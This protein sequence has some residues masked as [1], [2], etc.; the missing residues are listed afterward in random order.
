MNKTSGISIRLTQRD[1]VTV[2]KAI[3]KLACERKSRVTQSMFALEAINTGFDKELSGYVED[4]ETGQDRI[5]TQI[6][7]EEKQR[8]VDAA[9]KYGLRPTKWA[10]LAIKAYCDD[11]LELKVTGHGLT[12]LDAYYD[13]Q[14]LQHNGLTY[15]RGQHG[16]ARATYNHLDGGHIGLCEAGTGTG[17]AYAC[18]T[19]AHA[20]AVDKK[21]PVV[22]ATYTRALQKQLFET[23]GLMESV[24][25]KKINAAVVYGKRNYVSPTRIK[26]MIEDEKTPKQDAQ[27]LQAWAKETKTW[28]VAD[29]S[30]LLSQD[31]PIDLLAVDPDTKDE[32]ELSAY[33][34]SLADAETADI[35][36][37][38]HHML[39]Y[40]MM[41]KKNP[42]FGFFPD[43]I[44]IDEAH[45]F[46]QAA[47]T[48]L[49]KQVA[50]SSI[51]W[52][53][54]RL[55][56]IKGRHQKPMI[57]WK[58]SLKA[59]A[60]SIVTHCQGNDVIELASRNGL[61][62][63]VIASK[64][65][66]EKL[67]APPK[68]SKAVLNDMSSVERAAYRTIT[69]S[70]SLFKE[71]H[72]SLEAKEPQY[73]NIHAT[74]SPVLK[75]VRI[76]SSSST[77]IAKD[78]QRIVWDK[79]RGASLLSATMLLPT[80]T[81]E[82]AQFFINSVGLKDKDVV[83]EPPTHEAW[84]YD[85]VTIYAAGAEFPTPVSSEREVDGDREFWLS[86]VAEV[87]QSIDRKPVTA[88][89]GGIMVLCTSYADAAAIE[90][91]LVATQ[92]KLIVYHKHDDMRNVVSRF[93]ALDGN[94]ILIGLG[95]LWTGVDLPGNLLTDL[96]ITRL[97]IVSA[98]EKSVISRYEYIKNNAGQGQAFASVLLPRMAMVLRQGI[99][100]VCRSESDFGRVYI[101]DP[102]VVTK[103]RW[104]IANILR[105]YEPI[106]HLET[107]GS[108]HE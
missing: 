52:G 102:R 95:G 85:N 77:F 60:K 36:I 34:K 100:R 35:I 2:E 69:E 45:L 9:A 106:L 41:M 71:L 51:Q 92:R 93:K 67:S 75:H 105:K 94:G 83:V 10:V 1:L 63:G 11:I 3:V 7:S 18:L 59:L 13:K 28:L 80:K 66:V 65:A 62:M 72:K 22:I 91:K 108:K 101:T 79:V 17:K 39:I 104:R 25:G 15:R 33:R 84:T 87:V 61:N 44:I 53:L 4:L 55:I 43:H 47:D 37:T 23:V 54:D 8:M 89:E 64:A 99:G 56:G 76:I 20:F 58:Q 74:L 88:T 29:L 40:A 12:G 26:E 68:V 42:I 98:S 24:S 46:E 103:P 97:P 38:S 50:L 30:E 27:T 90:A 73:V 21:T 70:V 48:V 32:L 57:E 82:S 96:V 19:A 86:S 49:G 16:L 107:N 81:G 14:S 78:I 5:S 6:T 31:F